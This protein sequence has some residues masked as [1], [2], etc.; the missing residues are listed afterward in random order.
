MPY[1]RIWTSRFRLRAIQLR[2]ILRCR[3]LP[4]STVRHVGRRKTLR[5]S[6]RGFSTACWCS[7]SDNSEHAHAC[8]SRTPKS[9]KCRHRL[10]S[11]DS[12]LNRYRF[13]LS[14]FLGGLQIISQSNAWSKSWLGLMRRVVEV[15]EGMQWDS[16]LR[17]LRAR[18]PT[19]GYPVTPPR[20]L[21]SSR[22]V[23]LWVN[24]SA[25]LSVCPP[26]D[27]P[28]LQ[29]K[30]KVF[31]FRGRYTCCTSNCRFS[32]WILTNWLIILQRPHLGYL[33]HR[34]RVQWS[35]W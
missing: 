25:R 13:T 8:T 35:S 21:P 6:L 29:V 31:T 33:P 18:A 23:T 11:R 28:L 5:Y 34:P 9:R 22:C 12:T 2:C 4:T 24:G 3:L 17:L 1:S 7:H 16:T 26:S 30:S 20:L 32:W 27:D 10:F 15:W 19:P 14:K